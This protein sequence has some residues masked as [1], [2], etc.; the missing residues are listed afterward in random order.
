MPDITLRAHVCIRVSTSGQEEHGISLSREGEDPGF[1]EERC[2]E[3][4][5][6]NRWTVAEVYSDGGVSGR[7]SS[8]KKRD[9]MRRCID[10]AC[11]DKGV[12]V[13]YDLSRLGRS[14]G[15]LLNTADQLADAGA[16]LAAV[17][18]KFDTT[19]AMGKFFYGICALFAE[20]E[21]NK[22][23]ERMRD[24]HAHLKARYKF[25]TLGEVPY[26]YSRAKRSR[27]VV[28]V[29]EEQ[30]VIQ[31]AFELRARKT[32][33]GKLWPLPDVAAELNALGYLRRSGKPWS[34][35]SVW[36]ILYGRTATARTTL[37]ESVKNGAG[38][39]GGQ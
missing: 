9:E 10:N 8:L 4:C 22:H 36:Q 3:L 28:E 20:L 39:A 16:H 1:Q 24:V 7:R 35:A 21:S 14:A 38:I 23:G 29:A 6:F 13:I 2:R 32:R 26:G 11:R 27:I 31:K 34:G 37:A 12:V 25:N 30:A 17:V 5:Q 33:L 15:F 18:Q 19:S